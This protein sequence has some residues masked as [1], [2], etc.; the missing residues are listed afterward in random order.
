MIHVGLS[1]EMY[2]QSTVYACACPYT[3]YMCGFVCVCVSECTNV[4]SDMC[5]EEKTTHQIIYVCECEH[6]CM[7]TNGADACVFA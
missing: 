6:L 5:T 1:Q 4:C 3:V 7:C 2:Q